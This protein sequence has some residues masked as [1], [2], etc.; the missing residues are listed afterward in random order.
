MDVSTFTV[1]PG[2][3]GNGLQEMRL[4]TPT[5]LIGLGLRPGCL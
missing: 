5:A 1:E 3:A 2:A 4:E